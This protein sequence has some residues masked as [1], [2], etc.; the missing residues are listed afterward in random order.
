MT[1]GHRPLPKKLLIYFVCAVLMI[2]TPPIGDFV[3]TNELEG[4]D[5]LAGDFAGAIDIVRC[6]LAVDDQ[7]A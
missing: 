7:L 3:E 5:H 6:K 1:N 2:G 4:I